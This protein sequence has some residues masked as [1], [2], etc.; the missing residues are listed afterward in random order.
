[1]RITTWNVERVNP[2]GWRIAPAQLRRMTEV[3]ADI[4]L[5]TETDVDLVGVAPHADR[6]AGSPFPWTVSAIAHAPEGDLLVSRTVTPNA[7]EKHFDDGATASMQ[8]AHHAKAEKADD[9]GRLDE[10]VTSVRG[11][12]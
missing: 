2:K 8:E 5:L 3:D 11:T 4:W 12:G 1:M 7:N 9:E 10:F 6:R